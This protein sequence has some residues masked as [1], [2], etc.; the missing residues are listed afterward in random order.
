MPDL[1]GGCLTF[2]ERVTKGFERDIEPDLGAI[3]EAVGDRF[4]RHSDWY[5]NAIDL[6]AFDAGGER[7]ATRTENSQ[8]HGRRLGDP[9][10]RGE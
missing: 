5:G 1:V 7:L 6:V 3:S 4:G 8:R 9:G 2:L 10:I